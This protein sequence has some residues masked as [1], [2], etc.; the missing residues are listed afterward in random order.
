MFGRYTTGPGSRNLTTAT[1]CCQRRGNCSTPNNNAASSPITAAK[2]SPST[3]QP[4]HPKAI[5]QL[6]RRPL[7]ESEAALARR[8][9][10]Q[11]VTSATKPKGQA[12]S[13]TP[14]MK[15]RKAVTDNKKPDSPLRR[16]AHA[17]RLALML[18]RPTGWRIG[19]QYFFTIDRYVSGSRFCRVWNS[20]RQRRTSSRSIRAMQ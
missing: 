19:P 15:G 4:R 9:P 5:P 6:A 10:T 1:N 2:A 12:S 17:Q 16:L 8:R 11:P 7:T 3:S 14:T 13:E 20:S 18:S